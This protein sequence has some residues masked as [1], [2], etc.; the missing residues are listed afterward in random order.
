MMAEYT[1]RRSNKRP[2]VFNGKE[3]AHCTTKKSGDQG[4]ST[5][6]IFEVENG[7]GYVIGIAKLNNRIEVDDMYD[8]R[9]YKKLERGMQIMQKKDP[10]LYAMVA[11]MMNERKSDET[12]EK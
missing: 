5:A 2:I 12:K 3:I 4:W 11:V 6:R 7:L 10:D 9:L 8:A 1:L